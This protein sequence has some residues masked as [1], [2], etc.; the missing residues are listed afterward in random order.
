MRAVVDRVCARVLTKRFT[1]EGLSF[2]VLDLVTCPGKAGG[3][4]HMVIVYIFGGYFWGA[5]G[6][7][8]C[9]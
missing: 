7:I 2:W 9:K 3:R 6:F 8:V 1:R 5:H 4:G